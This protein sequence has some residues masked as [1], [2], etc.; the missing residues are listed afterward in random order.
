M[1]EKGARTCILLSRSG[2]EGKD[3]QELLE[4]MTT[5]GVNIAAPA[6]GISAEA[7]VSATIKELKQSMP[8]IKGYIQASMVLKDG[9]FENTNSEDF[10]TTTKPKVQG[11]WNL[12]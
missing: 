2:A 1:A 5:R 10:N 4:E 6:C 12:H 7:A 9:L 8:P 3:A 11:T